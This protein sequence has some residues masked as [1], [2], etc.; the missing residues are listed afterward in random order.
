MIRTPMIR[1]YGATHPGL[2]RD[3]NEDAF[4]MTTSNIRNLHYRQSFE[5]L[6]DALRARLQAADESE[7]KA[8]AFAYAEGARQS[9]GAD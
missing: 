9:P 5:M 8:P 1:S 6:A 3:N 2:Q 4:I 7:V